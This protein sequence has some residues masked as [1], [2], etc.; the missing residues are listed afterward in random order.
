MAGKND[1]VFSRA[2][3]R[4]QDVFMSKALDEAKEKQALIQKAMDQ[5]TSEFYRQTFVTLLSTKRAGM[6]RYS[7]SYARFKRNVGKDGAGFYELGGSLKQTMLAR[8]AAA[9]FG[10]AKVSFGKGGGKLAEG[11]KLDSLGRPQYQHHETG[12]VGLAKVANAFVGALGFNLRVE[13]F[14]LIKKKPSHEVFNIYPNEPETIQLSYKSKRMRKAKTISR[15]Q[16]GLQTKLKRMEFGGRGQ[17]ARPLLLFS[18]EFHR[19]QFVKAALTNLGMK[20]W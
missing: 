3:T 5:L 20:T 9:D 14:P 12:R 16:A 8:S 1:A 15:R 7:T 11:I 18:L 19:N 2:V 6:A 17:A 10:R 13:L 4:V